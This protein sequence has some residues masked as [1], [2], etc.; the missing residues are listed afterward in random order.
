[1]VCCSAC[2]AFPAL[3]SCAALLRCVPLRSLLLIKLLKY[4]SCISPH[5]PNLDHL[6]PHHPSHLYPCSYLL[7]PLQLHHHHSFLLTCR[8]ERIN[9]H[10]YAATRSNT[11][12]HAAARSNTEQPFSLSQGMTLLCFSSAFHLYYLLFLCRINIYL[13]TLKSIKLHLITLHH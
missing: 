4:V 12:Q 9:T 6:S 11:Q 3:R 8:I 13:G 2:R 7:S 1:M 5:S 10:Q